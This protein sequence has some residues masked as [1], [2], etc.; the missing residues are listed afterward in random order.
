MARAG[1]I[2]SKID[3]LE[4]VALAAERLET[5]AV[6]EQSDG[7]SSDPV[8]VKICTHKRKTNW[9]NVLIRQ[10]GTLGTNGFFKT[11]EAA[12][13][14]VREN[15]G[16]DYQ[17]KIQ[18]I[19]YKSS[20]S[21]IAAKELKQIAQGAWCEAFGVKFDDPQSIKAIIASSRKRQ[22]SLRHEIVEQLR[23]GKDRAA[24]W[25]SGLKKAIIPAGLL[26]GVDLSGLDLAGISLANKGVGS[27]DTDLQS[28]NFNETNLIRAN[29]ANCDLGKSTFKNAQLENASLRSAK[30]SSV[31]FQGAN[32]ACAQFGLC[33]A[34]RSNFAETNLT[35]A[36]FEHCDLRKA[37]FKSA[38]LQQATLHGVQA[39]GADFS[40]AKGHQA[41]LTASVFTEANF[42][43][44]K[45]SEANFNGATVTGVDFSNA[46]LR[47]CDFGGADLSGANLS[48]AKLEGAFFSYAKY[49]EQ[50]IFSPGEVPPPGLLW[51]GTG[52]Q[53]PTPLPKVSGMDVEGFMDY[54]KKNCDSGRIDK[55]L[56]MLK[57]ESF[58]LYSEIT[59]ESLVGIV[60][61]QTNWE[62]VYSCHLAYDGSFCCATQNL[63]YCGGMQGTLCKHILVL[64][65]GLVNAQ[66]LDP[67]TACEWIAASRRQ[68]P[69]LEKDGT[70]ATFLRYKGAESG[71]IDW[72]PTETIPEDYYAY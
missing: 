20:K 38:S 8:E 42:R 22:D 35:K 45:F 58:K 68:K 30:I 72:R 65:I 36:E 46:D 16:R 34:A 7:E 31:D 63:R 64:L 54:L 12:F 50:T 41:K 29:L 27:A 3:E 5:A 55:A 47:W 10:R 43:G 53:P 60:K 71:E 18:S 17:L 25:N 39:A 9:V 56:T 14:D 48:G 52:A 11:Y 19:S 67:N 69:V 70:S 32:M 40:D 28:I 51:A 57:T 62:L 37:S 59:M 2:G 23:K 33:D 24:M 49:N 15:L 4:K 66:Q 21:P 61:S 6:F 26:H 13:K 1:K 44:A